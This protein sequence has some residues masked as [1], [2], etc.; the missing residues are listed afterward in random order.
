MIK[1]EI[2][3]LLRSPS[4]YIMLLLPFL[5]IFFMS[6]GTKGYL[7]PLPPSPSSVSAP[8]LLYQGIL[9]N[10]QQQFAVSE[11]TFM[12]FMSTILL[13]LN[14][15]KERQT[16]VWNRVICKKRFLLIKSGVHAVYHLLLIT[17][18]LGLLY[19]FYQISYSWYDILCFISV[20]CISLPFAVFIGLKASSQTILSNLMLLSVMLLGYFGGALSLSSVLANTKG[21]NILRYLSPLTLVNQ[22]IYRD[23]LSCSNSTITI[24]WWSVVFILSTSLLILIQRRVTYDSII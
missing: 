15:L 3:Q 22:C 8:I 16:N 21:M 6:E 18:T 9:L 5:L 7:A 17:V 13:G 24:A 4:Y 11:L 12:L 20:S 23:I 1:K 10:A 14:I 19:F 2:K